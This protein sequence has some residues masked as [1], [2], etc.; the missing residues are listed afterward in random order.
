MLFFL[1]IAAKQNFIVDEYVDCAS[2][3]ID[4][5]SD[6]NQN[7]TRVTLCPLIKFSGEKR[8]DHAMLKK[9]ITGRMNYASLPTR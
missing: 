1:S 5:D 8:P 2:G 3:I 7:M 4:K 9:C 6:G